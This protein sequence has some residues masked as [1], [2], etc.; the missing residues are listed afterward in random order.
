MYKINL[1][2]N[3]KKIINL[4]Y[5]RFLYINKEFIY[6]TVENNDELKKIRNK[7]DE[8][9][10]YNVCNSNKI[11]IIN[12]YKLTFGFIPLVVFDINIIGPF[13]IKGLK[14]KRYFLIIIDKGFKAIWIYS[15]KFKIDAYDVMVDFCNMIIN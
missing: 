12:N 3:N 9:N 1:Y 4:Y 8:L 13:K 5:K 10:D 2:I 14:G 11:Y 6:K 7:N 15:L